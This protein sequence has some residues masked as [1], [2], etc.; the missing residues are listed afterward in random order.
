METRKQQLI[1]STAYP[2]AW[3]L[4]ETGLTFD[5]WQEERNKLGESVWKSLKNTWK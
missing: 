1:Q 2:E 5:E 4:E 3:E